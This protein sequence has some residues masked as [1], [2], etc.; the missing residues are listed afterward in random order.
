MA[1]NKSIPPSGSTPR[2]DP[3]HPSSE[4]NKA[5]A[6][7]RGRSISPG[8]VPYDHF[9]HAKLGPRETAGTEPLN[10]HHKVSCRETPSPIIDGKKAA[11]T[12]RYDL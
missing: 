5:T 9:G 10:L 12:A 7:Y 4:S 11:G 3:V 2:N 8:R 6:D 1:Y